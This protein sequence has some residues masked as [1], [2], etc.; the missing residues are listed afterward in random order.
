VQQLAVRL[1]ANA[2]KHPQLRS[3]VVAERASL[4]DS[5]AAAGASANKVIERAGSRKLPRCSK[6]WQCRHGSG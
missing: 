5:M 4:L 2:F 3:W 6:H 1:V